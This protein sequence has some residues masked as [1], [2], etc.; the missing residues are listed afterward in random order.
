VVHADTHLLTEVHYFIRLFVV[1][2]L[3][4]GW[5]SIV[6]EGFDPR[7]S[8]VYEWRIGGTLDQQSF[9]PR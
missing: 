8:G 9:C 2:K 5:Y 7:F 6:D 1:N 4:P 3:R